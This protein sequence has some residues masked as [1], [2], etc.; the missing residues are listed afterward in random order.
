MQGT[1]REQQDMALPLCILHGLWLECFPHR[2]AIRWRVLHVEVVAARFHHFSHPVLAKLVDSLSIIFHCGC[3]L[4]YTVTS[5]FLSSCVTN[6]FTNATLQMPLHTAVLQPIVLVVLWDLEKW[7]PSNAEIVLKLCS[8]LRGIAWWYLCWRSRKRFGRPQN[9]TG[10]REVN[11]QSWKPTL[12][13]CLCRVSH[14]EP[15]WLR[16]ITALLPTIGPKLPKSCSFRGSVPKICR[17]FLRVLAWLYE[18]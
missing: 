5:Q 2:L 9:V 6:A 11:L 1:T 7:F 17:F 16:I 18:S 15:W 13:W 3:S 8:P 12:H 4:S 10:L 14:F